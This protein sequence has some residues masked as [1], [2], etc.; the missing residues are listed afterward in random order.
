MAIFGRSKNRDDDL[1]DDVQDVN[2]APA[3]D[4]FAPPDEFDEVIG[5]NN[6][7]GTAGTSDADEE[8][9]S[10]KPNRKSK[11]RKAK[12]G[13]KQEEDEVEEEP[14]KVDWG[15]PVKP[16][17]SL[18]SRAIIEAVDRQAAN[19]KMKKFFIIST[20]GLLA[21]G[22]T[23]LGLNIFSAG[24]LEGAK[25]E[26]RALESAVS[27]LQPIADYSTSYQ[28][29]KDAVTKVLSKGIDYTGIQKVI[30][31]AAEANGVLIKSETNT[32]AQCLSASPFVAP[33]GLGCMSLTVDGDDNASISRFAA[34][35]VGQD[36]GIPDAYITGI[37]TGED[38]KSS[39]TMSF[40]YDNKLISPR[41]RDFAGG[42]QTTT[43]TDG[44]VTAPSAGTTTGGGN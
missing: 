12:G 29:R 16:S 26:G 25:S 3:P 32:N 21:F 36:K 7:D 40:N 41:Y 18:P 28:A 30:F 43:G 9:D 20:A 13:R 11:G 10:K 27:Q 17:L 4:G 24:Q 44:T 42:N 1:V 35:I 15:S 34:D 37:T 19:Q 22:I 39:A 6:F 33:T 14:E 23:A 5:L 8:E 2:D 31:D 38:G